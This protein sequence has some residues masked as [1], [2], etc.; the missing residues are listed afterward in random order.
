MPFD[1]A[2]DEQTAT[3]SRKPQFLVEITPLT[4][5]EGQRAVFR[6]VVS[7]VPSATI[8]WYHKHRL[9][10]SSR[11]F[12]VSAA[13]GKLGVSELFLASVFSGRRIGVSI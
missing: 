1:I 2:I 7:A 10:K 13:T 12:Q 4:A 6:S 3:A 5:Q 11:D 8:S 9:I